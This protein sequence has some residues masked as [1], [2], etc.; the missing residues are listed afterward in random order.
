VISLLRHLG[1]DRAILVGAGLGSTISLRTALAFPAR[2]R[3]MALISAEDIEDDDAKIAETKL[4]EAFAARVR[5]DGL[6][7]GWARILPDLAPLIGALVTEAIP[8]SDPRSIAAAAAI[9]R[10]RSFRTVTELSKI[11]C[12]TLVFPGMDIRHPAAIA[13]QLADVI[14]Q[15]RIAPITMTAEL[16]TADDFADTFAGA[17]RNFIKCL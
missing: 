4:F 1:I 12:P 6:R 14:P 16:K 3:A 13:K 15:G 9:G 8:R 2:V 10:D 5:R 7:A 11:C 17:I